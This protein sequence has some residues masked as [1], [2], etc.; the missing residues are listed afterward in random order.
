MAS[1]IKITVS[2]TGPDGYFDTRESADVV[3]LLPKE[4]SEVDARAFFRKVVGFIAEDRDLMEV[5][6]AEQVV[7]ALEAAEAS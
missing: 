4:I 1:Q 6:I 3:I 2:R 5:C 7:A